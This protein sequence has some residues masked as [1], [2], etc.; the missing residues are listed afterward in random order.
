MLG[1]IGLALLV[2]VIVLAAFLGTSKS[3]TQNDDLKICTTKACISA[4]KKTA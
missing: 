3:S 1:A 4:G 2:A